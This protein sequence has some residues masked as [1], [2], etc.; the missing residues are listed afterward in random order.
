VKHKAKLRVLLK[1]LKAAAD[2]MERFARRSDLSTYVAYNTRQK[3][4]RLRIERPMKR[5]MRNWTK[6][7][8]RPS[9]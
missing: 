8:S 9:D 4:R 3:V 2:A 6:S 7:K 1:R 5:K